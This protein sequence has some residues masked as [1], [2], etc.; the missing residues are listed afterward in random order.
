MANQFNSIFTRKPKRNKFNLSFEN[1]F[2]APIGKLVPVMTQ[3]V[4]PGDKMFLNVENI[5]R[6]QPLAAPMMQRVDVSFHAFYV[7]NRL[8]WDEWESFITGGQDGMEH[9]EKPTLSFQSNQDDGLAVPGSLLDYLGFPTLNDND[10]KVDGFNSQVRYTAEPFLVYGKIWN[11]YFRDQNLEDEIDLKAIVRDANGSQG[12]TYT[13]LLWYLHQQ[14]FDFNNQT[15]TPLDTLLNRSYPKDY[16]TSA[17]PSPQRGAEV[18]VPL[19][20][21]GT[22]RWV[23]DP[24][25][26][27]G[28]A[29]RNPVTG[30]FVNVDNEARL[31]ADGTNNPIQRNLQADDADASIDNS[32]H[33]RADLSTVGPTIVDLRRAF[34]VQEWEEKMSR[35]GSRYIEQILNFFGVRSSDARLQ[36]AEYLGGIRNPIVVSPVYQTSQSMVEQGENSSALG[37]FAGNGQ[38]VSK[39]F[40]VK[41]HFEEHGWVMV[42]M[43]VTPKASYFQGLPKKYQRFD[44]LDYYWP[45]FAH[46]GEQVIGKN[47]LLFDPAQPNGYDPGSD[48]GFGYSPRF[49]EYR[50]N[51]D[52]IHGEFKSNLA[53]W[54][55]ARFLKGDPTLNANFIHINNDDVNRV[56]AVDSELAYP[57]IC[58]IFLN[59]KMSRLI[60][61]YG[62]PRL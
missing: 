2:T 54:T 18:T 39:G 51:N 35:G 52:E 7:P 13:R 43:S 40:L 49:A 42:L 20:G 22:V 61:R 10:M 5:I 34:K 47:E 37:M 31:N 45:Q 53:Y 15:A 29:V 55:M 28:D 50:F 56:F 17:L 23:P 58:D 25:S 9:P 26:E 27:R 14:K 44:K 41:R 30:S 33:L 12:I 59:C 19:S 38:S 16:F 8:I 4:I 46:I 24:R 6:M 48:P 60:S 21:E 3:E 57:L 36:R 11:D 62:N 1:R 32:S